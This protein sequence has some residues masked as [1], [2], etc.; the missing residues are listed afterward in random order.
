MTHVAGLGDRPGWS[1][2]EV[3][4]KTRQRRQ[5][6]EE[7]IDLELRIDETPV[8]RFE[9]DILAAQDFDRIYRSRPRSPER[10]LMLA[11]LEE[12]LNDYQ[13]CWKA[14]DKKARQRFADAR[15]WILNT[16]SEWIFA[17]TNC[18]EVLGIEPYYLRQ[19]VLRW[20]QGKRARLLSARAIQHQT[21]QP[22][23]LRQAA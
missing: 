21:H 20:K 6:Q 15:A 10:D 3:A 23:R 22:K 13:R 2:G 7:K 17:F 16:D 11:I 12:A 9:A 8:V 14:R 4:M 1:L 5:K 19:G 18:C